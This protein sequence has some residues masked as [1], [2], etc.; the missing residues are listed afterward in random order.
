MKSD[1]SF[2]VVNVYRQS[3]GITELEL[4]IPAAGM[5]SFDKVDLEIYIDLSQPWRI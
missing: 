4:P 3:C 2:E 1:T 5:R